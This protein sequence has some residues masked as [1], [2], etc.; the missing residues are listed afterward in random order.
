MK[1]K[2]QK[3]DSLP[4]SLDISILRTLLVRD[5]RGYRIVQ[6]IQQS[7]ENEFLVD[8]GSL[9]PALQRLELNG[10]IEGAWGVTSNH[11]RARIYKITTAG[12]KQIEAL[13]FHT[14]NSHVDD[15]PITALKGVKSCLL[16]GCVVTGAAF[17]QQPAYRVPS[18]GIPVSVCMEPAQELLISTNRAKSSVSAIFSQIGVNLTWHTGLSDC[19]QS[20]RTAFKI[21]WAERAPST[22]PAGALAA[23]RPFG[24]SETSITIYE[25]PLQRLFRHYANAPEEVV[26]AYVL[27]HEL[28]HVMQGLDHHSASGI[29]KASWSY[30]EYYRMLSRTLTFTAQDVELIRAGLEAK[31]SDIASREGAPQSRSTSSSNPSWPQ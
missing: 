23:A 18:G 5:L 13:T 7:S 10:W 11:R 27:A 9:Y 15:A 1:R 12:R 17:G 25:V 3:Y 26:L 14:Y 31:R 24:S 20:V 2:A 16:F 28:A 30:G 29:L 4:G 6:F 8:E 19:D 21:R 22:S